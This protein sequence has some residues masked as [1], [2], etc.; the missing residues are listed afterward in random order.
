M[1]IKEATAAFIAAHK[2]T[3]ID[4]DF[5][6][7]GYGSVERYLEQEGSL[8]GDDCG[9]RYIEISEFDTVS[10]TTELIEWHD[11][12]SFKICY[13]DKPKFELKTPEDFA[14]HITI[15]FDPDFDWAINEAFD[16]LKDPNAHDVTLT[17]YH[18]GEKYEHI[19]LHDYWNW[20]D[21]STTVR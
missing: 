11:H 3:R 14:A 7:F 6:E 16:L 8:T 12:E 9:E 5:I 2:P 21:S 13:F 19:N 17:A 18:D 4:V 1:N 15:V 10:G 20:A